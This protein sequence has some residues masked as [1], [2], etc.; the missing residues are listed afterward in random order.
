MLNSIVVRDCSP[1]CQLNVLT[2]KVLLPTLHAIAAEVSAI[3]RAFVTRIAG[4]MS[5]FMAEVGTLECVGCLQLA[6]WFDTEIPDVS[7]SEAQ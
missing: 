7:P 4:L 5:P 6:V 2:R 1:S 3:S